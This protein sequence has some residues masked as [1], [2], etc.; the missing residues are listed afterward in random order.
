MTR[1]DLVD[2]KRRDE[3]PLSD[4]RGDDDGATASPDELGGN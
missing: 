1:L 3:A 2:V 4:Q